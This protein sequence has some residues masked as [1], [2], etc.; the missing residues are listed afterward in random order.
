[1]S[2]PLGFSSSSAGLGF[3]SSSSSS[4]AVTS[5]D[6]GGGRPGPSNG[7]GGS[8]FT[9]PNLTVAEPETE[10]LEIKAT[11][12]EFDELSEIIEL[13]QMNVLSD[14]DRLLAGEVEGVPSE[15]EI[16]E[17]LQKLVEKAEQQGSAQEVELEATSMPGITG[18][19]FVN[20]EMQPAVSGAETGSE[21]PEPSKPEAETD[22]D[23]GDVVKLGTQEID[24]GGN[25]QSNFAQVQTNP[26][27]GPLGD[28]DIDQTNDLDDDDVITDPVVQNLGTLNQEINGPTDGSSDASVQAEL[29]T[30]EISTGDNQQ[31]NVAGIRVQSEGGPAYA[32]VDV[33][34]ANALSDADTVDNPEVQNL[35]TAT[36][37]VTAVAGSESAD[38]ETEAAAEIAD[39]NEPTIGPEQIASLGGNEATNVASIVDMGEGKASLIVDGDYHLTTLIHQSIVILDDDEVGFQGSEEVET[40]LDSGENTATNSATWL[41]DSGL[42]FGNA[43]LGNL[44]PGVIWQI[45]YVDDDYYDVTEIY[46]ETTLFDN[47]VNVQTQIN[48]YSNVDLGG[49][50]IFNE[51]HAFE[52]WKDYDLIIVD[53][54]YLQEISIYQTSVLLDND[55]LSLSSKHEADGEYDGTGTPGAQVAETSG[56][57]L[58][59]DASIVTIGSDDRFKDLDENDHVED[60]VDDIEDQETEFD[61]DFDLAQEL[62]GNGSDIMKVL[63]V[64]G[65][66]YDIKSIYQKTVIADADF[67]LQDI[68]SPYRGE[69]DK[70]DAGQDPNLDANDQALDDLEE[71]NLDTFMQQVESGGNTQTNSASIVDVASTSG[72][73]YLGG[74]FYRSDFLHQAEFVS[75]DVEEVHEKDSPEEAL[76]ALADK[77][78]AEVVEAKEHLLS[79]IGNSMDDDMFSGALG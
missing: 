26:G 16:A 6:A 59:N 2:L 30:Q 35:G 52:N 55:I 36:Q 47:D 65:D 79:S 70:G 78:G 38:G 49:N 8:P 66:Y 27:A 48:S 69:A 34:Q 1:T 39:A 41:N 17:L 3:Q 15:E 53:G 11:Y 29:L 9:P 37:S 57:E 32:A 7:G 12:R 75:N 22:A 67:S 68:A 56:N 51:A 43:A 28:I 76:A 14:S 19:R 60:L 74:D 33:E 54:D 23:L 25:E 73:Q 31:T 71:A 10:T 18:I 42:I 21:D 4:N 45:D 40:T 20:G 62:P 24:T 5:S 13:L 61:I 50:T 63:F 58:F 46:Q 77:T 64:D 72:F 44:L